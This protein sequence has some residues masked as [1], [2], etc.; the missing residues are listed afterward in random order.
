MRL[1]LGYFKKV[2]PSMNVAEYHSAKYC[3]GAAG[4][5]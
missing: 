5:L 2:S 4:K 1:S 3:R